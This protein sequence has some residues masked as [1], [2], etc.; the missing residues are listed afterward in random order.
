MGRRPE[1][2]VPFALRTR[3]LAA[4]AAVTLLLSAAAPVALYSIDDTGIA[5]RTFQAASDRRW[6][7]MPM[8]EL[9]ATVGRY[10]LGHPY[11]AK[12]L[13]RPGDETLVV[14]LT[15]LDCTTFVETSLA[16]ARTIRQGRYHFDGFV[17]ELQ[18]IRYRDG[19]VAGYPSRLHYFSDWLYDNSRKGLVDEITEALGGERQPL[20]VNFM[21]QHPQ[22]YMQLRD[23]ANVLAMQAIETTIT[24]RPHF[25]ILKERIADLD[26]K[27]QTGDVIA[28]V[29]A[30][31]GLDVAHVGLAVREN[32]GR[33]HL[34]NAPMAGRKV[35]VSK[36][37]L[38]DLMTNRKA[39]TGIRVARPLEPRP[40]EAAA[41]AK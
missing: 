35:E 33:I 36:E 24:A 14:D 25:Q 41:P 19:I 32:D 16:M 40:P 21:T 22:A 10:F 28:L 26:A 2:P 7:A 11:K 9:V 23:P 29:P 17:H 6:A 18:T 8:G 38:A 34:L 39:Y 3:G 12:T 31:P 4:L 1:L 30:I 37:T 20:T 15:G 13:E 5:N 27:L